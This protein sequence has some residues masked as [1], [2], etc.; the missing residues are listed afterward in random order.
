MTKINLKVLLLLLWMGV[1]VHAQTLDQQLQRAQ[2]AGVIATKENT[3]LGTSNNVRLPSI[4]QLNQKRFFE[5]APEGINSLLVMPDLVEEVET[6]NLT[7]FFPKGYGY[8]QHYF[9]IWN[10]IPFVVFDNSSLELRFGLIFEHRQVGF[11]PDDWI[12]TSI[13]SPNMP[14]INF[15]IPDSKIFLN[16]AHG[17]SQWRATVLLTDDQI[18]QLEAYVNGAI[19]PN[20]EGV[21]ITHYFIDSSVR[22]YMLGLRHQ[23]F[24]DMMLKVY[25]R[26][27][28]FPYVKTFR[29]SDAFP[30]EGFF[31]EFTIENVVTE[32]E[33]VQVSTEEEIITIT[34]E[35]GTAEEEGD[36]Y[37]YEDG[38][39]YYEDEEVAE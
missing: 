10:A 28:E 17:S 15:L 4:G 20:G 27:D 24:F 13:T 9:G 29:G 16:F 3:K 35:E 7:V 23:S 18:K 25:K 39:Y 26:I 37:Y 38:E 11:I 33:E 19:D 22:P 21:L 1:L 31:D 8:N 34:N 14:E 2:E 6:G 36:E 5:K 32:Q 12:S 30:E